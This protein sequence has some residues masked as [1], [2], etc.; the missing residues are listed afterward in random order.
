MM[1]ALERRDEANVQEESERR[2]GG[3]SVEKPS[4]EPSIEPPTRTQAEHEEK[5]RA[6]TEVLEL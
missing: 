2:E 1:V 5:D 4:H 6:E 3:R